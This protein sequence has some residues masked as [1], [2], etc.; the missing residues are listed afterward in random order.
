[1]IFEPLPL[2]SMEAPELRLP[3]DVTAEAELEQERIKALWREHCPEVAAA[4]ERV[5]EAR[6]VHAAALQ[7]WQKHSQDL[8]QAQGAIARC[9]PDS[10]LGNREDLQSN[11]AI[12][13]GYEL[14]SRA[15]LQGAGAALDEALNNLAAANLAQSERVSKAAN[16]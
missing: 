1:M 9:G 4:H 8:M 15:N 3:R 16:P 2:R 10:P 7:R 5:D 11:V 14:V 12:A 6:I 13:A